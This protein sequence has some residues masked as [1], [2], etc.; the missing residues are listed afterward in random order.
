MQLACV[1]LEG[2]AAPHRAPIMAWSLRLAW[3]HTGALIG[4]GVIGPRRVSVAGCRMDD[5]GGDCL[6]T[7]SRPWALRC[8]VPPPQ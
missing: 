2:N 8:K 7:V 1:P 4:V 6:G 5:A 3:P